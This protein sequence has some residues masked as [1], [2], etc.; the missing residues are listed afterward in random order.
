[1]NMIVNNKVPMKKNESSI[2]NSFFTPKQCCRLPSVLAHAAKVFERL[3]FSP[4][5]IIKRMTCFSRFEL[6]FET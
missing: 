6:C 2:G 3:L 4:F 1:M 5:E